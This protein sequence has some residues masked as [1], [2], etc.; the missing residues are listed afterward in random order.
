M[1]GGE[2]GAG[3]AVRLVFIYWAFV[4]VSLRPACFFGFLVKSDFEFFPCELPASDAGIV[5]Y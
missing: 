1:G 4:A 2:R 3:G 5:C